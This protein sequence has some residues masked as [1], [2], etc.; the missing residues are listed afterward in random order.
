MAS[1]AVAVFPVV[2]HYCDYVLHA[3]KLY[4]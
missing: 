1:C 3:Y 2:S 4:S